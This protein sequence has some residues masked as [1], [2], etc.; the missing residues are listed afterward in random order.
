MGES[1]PSAAAAFLAHK[2]ALGRKYRSEEAALRLLVAFADEH[3]A[4]PSRQLTP[5]LLDAFMASRPRTRPRSLN[6]LVGIVGCF[7]DWAA[8]QQL[9][10]VAAAHPQTAGDGPAHPVPVRHRP[11]PPAP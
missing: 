2:R 7:L 1:L 6:E 11:G 8:T 5:E 9:G 10:S 3:G 4:R